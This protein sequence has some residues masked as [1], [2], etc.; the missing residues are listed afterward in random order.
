MIEEGKK[1]ENYGVILTMN[2]K[3]CLILFLLIA[4]QLTAAVSGGVVSAYVFNNEIIPDNVFIRNIDVSG[5]TKTQALEK[6]SSSVKGELQ[7][8]KLVLKSQDNRFLIPFEEIEA[9][10]DVETSVDNAFRIAEKD[11]IISTAF[12][13]F[14]MQLTGYDPIHIPLNIVYNEEILLQELTEIKPQ[15]EIPASKA[16]LLVVQNVVKVVPEVIGSTVN[17]TKTMQNIRENIHNTRTFD[18]AME[19]VVPDV[20]AA[21]F[22]GIHEM[23]GE[24]A[25]P[26]SDIGKKDTEGME[27]AVSAINKIVVKAGA[28]ISLVD[29][30]KKHWKETNEEVE[31]SNN[32]GINQVVTTLYNALLI[33]DIPVVERT[34]EKFPVRYVDAGREAVIEEPYID[35]VFKND[36]SYPILILVSEEE[37][38]IKAKIFGTVEDRDMKI[39]IETRDRKV[40]PKQVEA[41]L[42][43]TLPKGT[44]AVAYEGE[45]GFSISVY[46]I[47]EKNGEKIREEKVS[48]DIYEPKNQ[49]V[50]VGAKL[51][52]EEKGILK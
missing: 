52:E 27:F 30:F 11:N 22:E 16:S 7:G 50:H 29:L 31:L 32:Q 21:D 40:V 12:N 44:K 5:L 41:K 3:K 8:E 42:D 39:R 2:F 19:D 10:Y 17:I 48:T 37:K 1:I 25:T 36:N 49:I 14:K 24:F 26:I 4:V 43:Y 28:Q 46:K 47:F 33:S 9:K 18:I 38:E 6:V 23:I 20:T 35:L 13:S 51:S 45:D 34:C 15:L